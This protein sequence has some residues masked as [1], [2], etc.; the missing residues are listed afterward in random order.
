MLKYLFMDKNAK[1]KTRKKY[2]KSDGKDE[3]IKKLKGQVARAFADYD[4]LRK[5]AEKEVEERSKVSKARL[6]LKLLSVY[7]MLGD[8][9]RHVKDQ[10]LEI[11]L[12]EFK[13]VIREEGVE[14]IE[15]KIGDEFDEDFFEAV[16]VVD[17]P[18]GGKKKRGTVSGVVLAGW[19]FRDGLVIRPS[20]VKVFKK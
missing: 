14:E 10:G 1:I 6:I 3:E 12:E 5:R 2:K 15:T 16:E 17:P 9:Q 19:M 20:K 4:N 11:A 7:D 8:V 13:N 18:T